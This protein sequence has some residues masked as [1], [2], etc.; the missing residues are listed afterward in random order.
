M[1]NGYLAILFLNLAIL[2]AGLESAYIQVHTTHQEIS[3]DLI[4]SPSFLL[5]LSLDLLVPL[6]VALMSRRLFFA[7]LALHC[8][9]NIILLHYNIFFYNPLTLSTIY[10]SMQGAASLGVDILGFARGDIIFVALALF[11]VKVFLVQLSMAPDWGMPRFWGLRGITAVVSTAIIWIISMTIYGQNG[12]SLL[13]VDSRGHRTATERRMESGTYEAVRNIGYVAT[14][15]GEW[16]SGTYRDTDL[17]F[18]EKRCSD[19][20]LPEETV[21]PCPSSHW[22]GLPV[23]PVTGSTVVLVQVESLDFAALDMKVNGHT[24]LPFID[25]LA[26]DS[27]LLKA[28]APH[29]VGSCNSDYEL[30]NGRV[31]EQN[32][33]YYTYI[34]E[35]P[36]SLI[37]TIAAK[38]YAPALFHG[39]SGQIFNLRA[40]YTAQ[41]FK[42]FF[43][44]EELL[45][46][47][48]APSKYIMEH[49]LDEDVFDKAA[50]E[51][52]ARSNQAQFIVTMSSHIPFMD[53]LPIFKTAG[54]TFARY[55]SSLRYMDQS[56]AA[57]YAKLPAGTLFILWG[58]HG[59]DVEYPQGFPENSRHVPF[60]VHVKGDSAWMRTP[61]AGM[62]DASCNDLTIPR[63][64]DELM[65]SLLNPIGKQDTPP[66]ASPRVFTLCELAHYLRK[67]FR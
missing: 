40:A 20:G 7:Y 41:G 10:H 47:G 3:F 54:G 24:V 53:P 27:L 64:P 25:F 46:N 35:Y 66:L 21:V 16:M 51:L 9:L 32:V 67:I 61:S 44:K 65:D 52:A 6:T 29:K 5:L 19:P 23:P 36:D 55:V 14:W 11:F 13:W 49:I 43:F 45:Q 37:H 8:V 22:G 31:A 42:R 39:L 34:K 57:Y 26:Q 17:I 62:P 60:L 15:I 33:I 48:Y 12:L 58:D 4:R 63:D 2:M 50:E 59:S 30:L 18:A 1:Q 56:L 28:F 38:G